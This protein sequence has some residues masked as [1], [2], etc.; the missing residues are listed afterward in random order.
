MADGK[1]QFKETRVYMFV[2][3]D[4]KNSSASQFKEARIQ[5]CTFI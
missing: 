1:G 5:I 3:I 2:Y 4:Q